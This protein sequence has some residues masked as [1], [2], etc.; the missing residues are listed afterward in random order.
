ML[1]TRIVQRLQILAQN[2]IISPLLGRAAKV[3][4]P[5][6]VR[7]F[8][9]FPVLRRIPARLIGVGIRPEHVKTKAVA[10]RR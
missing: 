5:L 1:A 4:A 6:P 9:R 8:Q 2:R 3:T 10:L 7:L